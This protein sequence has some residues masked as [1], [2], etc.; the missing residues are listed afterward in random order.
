MSNS[1][2]HILKYQVNLKK[3]FLL[4]NRIMT[5]ESEIK[6]FD[7]AYKDFIVAST[8]LTEKKI[9][10][11]ATDARKALMTIRNVSKTLGKSIL[12]YKNSIKK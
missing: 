10:S 3:Y 12:E 2:I 6:E 7:K 8:L 1:F 4:Y 11:R 9:K 5:L